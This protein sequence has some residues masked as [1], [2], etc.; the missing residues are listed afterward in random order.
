MLMAVVA[1]FLIAYILFGM[2]KDT[3]TSD[4]TVQNNPAGNCLAATDC[5][6][7]TTRVAP[8]AQQGATFYMQRMG[9]DRLLP[10]G[11]I[12][13]STYPAPD[14]SAQYRDLFSS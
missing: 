14:P 8:S 13:L 11:E 2:P 6:S 3:S 12:D 4:Y 9:N 7:A 10:S 5:P 1:A